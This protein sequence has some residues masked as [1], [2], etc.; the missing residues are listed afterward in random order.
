[1]KKTHLIPLAILV[2]LTFALCV[3]G[4]SDASSDS[5]K[6]GDGVTYEFDSE[7]GTL[8]IGGT[9]TMYEY[10]NN[11]PWFAYKDSVK[12]VIV[13]DG[14][15]AVSDYAFLEHASLESVSISASVAEIGSSA[16]FGCK[17]LKSISVAE[18]NGNYSSS[19]GVLFDKE[20]TVLMLY[21]AGSEA[22]S[23]AVPGSVRTIAEDAFNSS[24][25]LVS[26][27]IP[28]SVDTIGGSAFS[29]CAALA[30]ITIPDSVRTVS[31]RTFL[32]CTSLS[33]VV[34]GKGVVSLGYD[35]FSGCTSL[36]SV[37][38]SE[39][40]ETIGK[41]AFHDCTSL[42]AVTIP[43]SVVTI[44][45]SAFYK[46]TS[47]SEVVIGNGV[48]TIESGAFYECGAIERITFGTSLETVKSSAFTVRL[49]DTDGTTVL[50]P[51]ADALRGSVFLRTD[52]ILV[53]QETFT[54]T[55][56]ISDEESIVELHVAGDVLSAPAVT[57]TKDSDGEYVYVFVG[58]EG[59][60]DGMTVTGDMTF[61]AMFEK[62]SISGSEGGSKELIALAIIVVI[63]AVMAAVALGS[64][65]SI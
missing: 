16:F 56:K 32:N 49:Y 35:A 30:S 42:T 58:W 21:P 38:F 22:E 28:A 12:S 34:L 24:A 43:G 37:V 10:Y 2:S 31:D 8:T 61:T 65:K 36:M 29:R 50:E 40:L 63:F 59:F 19:D 46:C 20:L 57:P 14:V 47:L 53:K 26:V 44:D 33:E 51:S 27:T 52:G 39:S 55:F 41:Y 54:V 25:N 5:G 7:T 45:D 4:N 13:G 9:G 11:Q 3:A 64:R 15:T 18:G 17:I 1:M 48:K 62:Q 6:C 23:Y 60:E